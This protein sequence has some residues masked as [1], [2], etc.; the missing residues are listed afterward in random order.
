MRTSMTTGTTAVTAGNAFP[1]ETASMELRDDGTGNFKHLVLNAKMRAKDYLYRGDQEGGSEVLMGR[2]GDCVKEFKYSIFDTRSNESLV[3]VARKLVLLSGK[4]KSNKMA[5]LS[6][7]HPKYKDELEKDVHLKFIYSLLSAAGITRAFMNF[8][9]PGGSFK[10]H[11]DVFLS[12][13]DNC[14]PVADAEK[15]VQT[16]RYVHKADEG[17]AE[18]RSEPATTTHS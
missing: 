12:K 16:K 17:K 15:V 14:K 9:P 7:M 6:L 13:S 11:R 5:T 2:L 8:Y 1:V 4:K 18:F 3:I 10:F